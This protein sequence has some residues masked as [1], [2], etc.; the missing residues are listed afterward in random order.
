MTS[1]RGW[2]ESWMTLACGTIKRQFTPAALG[3]RTWCR[4]CCPARLVIVSAEVGL[5]VVPATYSGRLFRDELGMLN[6]Q[7]AEVCQE[8]LLVVAGLPITLR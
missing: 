5:G 7:L 2:L 4:R 3:A 8:V 1:P 6:A